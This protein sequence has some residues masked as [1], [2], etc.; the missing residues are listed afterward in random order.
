MVK[1]LT[2]EEVAEI[3][4]TSEELTSY[5]NTFMELDMDCSGSLGIDEMKMLMV[6]MGETF[7]KDEL[8]EILE[9]YDSDKSGELEFS[10]FVVMM[11]G[12][13]TQFG[14]GMEKMYNTAFKRGAIGR[15][16]REF[17]KWWNQVLGSTIEYDSFHSY[18][19][20][21]SFCRPTLI[22]KQLKRR[23][24]RRKRRRRGKRS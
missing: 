14:T 24:Q 5:E 11:K 23:K 8:Q 19:E 2:E 13:T 4:V 21:I 15:A 7:D 16:G 18:I 20:F 3:G 12:W 9:K 17:S 1:S 6:M 22:N 10:E